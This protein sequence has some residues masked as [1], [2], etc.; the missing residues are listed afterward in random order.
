MKKFFLHALR[1]LILTAP[2]L[3]VNGALLWWCREDPQL[4]K[5]LTY[6]LYGVSGLYTVIVTTLIAGGSILFVSAAS[7][8]FLRIR[9]LVQRTPKKEPEEG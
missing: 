6:C 2:F 3:V 8:E 7:K 4:R 5:V 1:I 9:V